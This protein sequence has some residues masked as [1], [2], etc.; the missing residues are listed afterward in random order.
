[1]ETEVYENFNPLKALI[2]ISKE[3]KD[4]ELKPAK[5]KKVLPLL[6][7]LG[8]YLGTDENQALIFTVIFALLIDQTRRLD[9]SD[10]SRYLS[11][12][13]MELL[14]YQKDIEVLINKKIITVKNNIHHANIPYQNANFGIDNELLHS[15]YN[16]E[17]MKISKSNEERNVIVFV[18]QVSDIIELRSDNEIS[19]NSL[20][21]EVEEMEN[22]YEKDV[23][24]INRLK[25][26]NLQTDYRVLFYEICADFVKTG[27]SGL[28]STVKD[29]F[30][31]FS[32]QIQW[33]K[34]IKNENNR[35]QELGLI[36]LSGNVMFSDAEL[37]LTEKGVDLFLGE[38]AKI[39]LKSSDNKLINPEK[40]QIKPL[41]Y[42]ENLKKQVDFLTNSLT[43]QNHKNLQNKLQEKSLPKG[44]TA[45]FYGSPGTGKTET[46]YQIAIQ[47]GR[48]ILQVD[49]SETKSMWYGESEKKIK[50]VF[51]NYRTICNN[52]EIT[53]I[54]LFNEADAIF[55]KRKDSNFSNVAQTENAMQNI[56]LE[57]MEKLDGILI[58]TTNLNQNLDSAFER[59]FLF[60][61]KFESPN[62]EI[63]EKIWK[64]RMPLLNENET[65]ILADKFA[66]SGGEIE[67]VIRKITMEEI[68]SDKEIKFEQILDFCEKEKFE[69]EARKIGY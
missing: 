10:I 56:I 9:T 21:R 60:K 68:L 11:V 61:V 47:T 38:D 44:V 31:S 54:L 36:K 64:S 25:I 53:P 23:E 50:E 52:S 57:E 40:L 55:S 45:I 59:R 37:K 22:D 43:I 35:L 66:L 8:E 1:M 28:E 24:I 42:A 5:I 17:P 67:N 20:I 16:N 13:Y 62:T 33:M 41:F 7:K 18:K 58:A 4:S 34:Q 32:Q 29:I 2:G 65:H 3:I 30:E 19:T 26:Y 14:A 15:I 69:K 6:N 12:N 48:K 39:F 27:S 63:K 49:I 51:E 46:V